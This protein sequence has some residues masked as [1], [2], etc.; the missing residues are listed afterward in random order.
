MAPRGYAVGLV[1][2][3]ARELVAV[4]QLPKDASKEVALDDLDVLIADENSGFWQ[5]GTEILPARA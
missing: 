2:D 1:E 3:E 5:E 4:V